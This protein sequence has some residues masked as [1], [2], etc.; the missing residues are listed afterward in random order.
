M[1]SLGIK[2][3][4]LILLIILILHVLIKN[5]IIDKTRRSV[6]ASAPTKETFVAPAQIVKKNTSDKECSKP[7]ETDITSEKE[8]LKYVY[9]DTDEDIEI[10]K[11]FKGL[12]VTKD[13]AAPIASK[14]SC[15]Q[16]KSTGNMLPESTTC[17]PPLKN[18]SVSQ[19]KE[20]VVKGDC[21]LTQPLNA[22]VLK[23]YEDENMMN[24][25]DLGGLS[26][27]DDD[28]LNFEGYDKTPCSI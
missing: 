22:M 5:A 7:F 8:F 10:D 16:K 13:I 28:A 1:L 18:S 27:Y 25:G 12:D 3:S 21:N 20:K 11:Y 26:A 19:L 23:V 15:N 14:L 24:G 4:I 17:D 2:N 6:K 9:E